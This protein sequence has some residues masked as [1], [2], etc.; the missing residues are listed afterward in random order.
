M[1]YWTGVGSRSITKEEQE[2]AVYVAETITRRFGMVLRS[3]AAEG[4]D[5]AFQKGVCNVNPKYC[6][7][8][9]PWNNFRPK[10]QH[11]G[12]PSC[13]YTTPT[14]EM[15]EKAREAFISTG[16]IPWFDRMKQGAQKLHGR[17]F[18]QVRGGYGEPL[19]KVCIYIA[20]EDDNG[21]VSGGTRSAVLLARH[22]KIPTYNLRIKE[23]RGLLLD[24]IGGKDD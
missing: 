8:W 3:G 23:Q 9:T 24:N 20:D 4:A 11:T 12:F 6:Q 21:E 10:E 15:F 1:R 2:L 19:S 14:T 7:I 17:N 16:I 13:S 22:Y 18:Y 5:T